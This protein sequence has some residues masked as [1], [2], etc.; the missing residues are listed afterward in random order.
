MTHNDPEK[1]KAYQ[2]A[3]YIAHKEKIKAASK[4]YGEAHKVEVAAY[5][6][7]YREVNREKVRKQRAMHYQAHKIETSI[8]NKAYR[9]VHKGEAAAYSKI[10]RKTHKKEQA[11]RRKRYYEAHKETYFAS[12]AARKALKQGVLIGATATQLTEIKEIYRIAHESPKVRCYLCGKL[13]P[14]GQRHVD[15]IVPLSKGGQHRPSNLAVACDK[16][17]MSKFNKLPEEVGVLL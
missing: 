10:Y 14:L 13:I 3:Y 7:I 4:A 16:C 6:K 11:I 15:H 12:A 17:N 2:R 8:Y 1:E 5:G 9:E